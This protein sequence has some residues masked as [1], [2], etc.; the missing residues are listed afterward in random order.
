MKNLDFI[1]L[2]HAYPNP[3]IRIRIRTR[4]YVFQARKGIWSGCLNTTAATVR[5]SSVQI[6]RFLKMIYQSFRLD[7]EKPELKFYQFLFSFAHFFS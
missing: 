6:F 2:V 3:T 1:N 7:A 5:D 4:A